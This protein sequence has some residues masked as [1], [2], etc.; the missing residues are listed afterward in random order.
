MSKS[1]TESDADLISSIV[2][3]SL[4]LIP[5]LPLLSIE[6]LSVPFVLTDKVSS[7]PPALTKSLPSSLPINP[8]NSDSL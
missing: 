7:D 8:I 3:G 5:I 2:V 1:V 6:T 4:V